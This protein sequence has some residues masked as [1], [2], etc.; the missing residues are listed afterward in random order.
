MVVGLLFGGGG[1]ISDR[2][3][4]PTMIKAGLR[5]LVGSW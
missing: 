4:K 1:D 3:E 5:N 2:L